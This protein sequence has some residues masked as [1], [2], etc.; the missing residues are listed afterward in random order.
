MRIETA[1]KSLIMDLSILRERPYSARHIGHA[2]S[3][4]G[5]K[6]LRRITDRQFCWRLDGFARSHTTQRLH[7][8]VAARSLRTGQD[9]C[10]PAEVAEI[11]PNEWNL[12][13]HLRRDVASSTRRNEVAVSS[14]L[15]AAMV[16]S[17]SSR[18]DVNMRLV[19]G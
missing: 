12:H 8:T 9:P 16:G 3:G 10:S 14:V 6:L 19:S 4:Q 1:T 18:S 15:I 5:R 13:A 11:F 2:T 7:A 17:I